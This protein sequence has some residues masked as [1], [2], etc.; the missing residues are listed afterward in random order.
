MAKHHLPT[1]V[2]VEL[3]IRLSQ[4]NYL[5]G[6]YKYHSVFGTGVMVK[7]SGGSISVIGINASEARL[8]VFVTANN[9]ELANN[10]TFISMPQSAN[11]VL[12]KIQNSVTTANTIV[13]GAQPLFIYLVFLMI[14][15]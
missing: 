4:H 15:L 14:L 3:L 1:Y 11:C 12:I 6:D 10:T 13:T 2:I 9:N 7:T 5:I 8:E